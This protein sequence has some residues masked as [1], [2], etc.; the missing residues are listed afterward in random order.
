M[1]S[2][3]PITPIGPAEPRRF[4]PVLLALF[5]GS[6]CAAVIREVVCL[7]F[8]QL[9]IGSSERTEARLQARDQAAAGRAAVGEDRTHLHSCSVVRLI[10][11]PN[12]LIL[13]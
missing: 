6:G 4:L 1:T 13:E 5:F 2:P 3:D 10:S 9:V 8:L 12:W 7:K 11:R